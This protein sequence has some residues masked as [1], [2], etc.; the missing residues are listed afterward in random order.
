MAAYGNGG[1]AGD[2]D[3][4]GDVDIYVT[5][6]GRNELWS[7]LGD[8]TFA[9]VTDDAGVGESLWSSAA[10]FADVDRDGDLDLYVGNYVDFGLDNHK[11]CGEEERGI[12][13][14]CHP[15]AYS[16]LPDTFYRNEGDG[17]FVERSEE[18][19]LAGK[20]LATLALSFG[21][22]DGDGWPDLYVANDANRN[23]LFFNRG[24]GTFE[25][26]ALLAGVAFGDSGNPEAG[27][28]VDFGDVDL[29][30]DLDIFVTNF[31]LETNVLY[32]NL[33]Q[34]VF[35]DARFASNVAESSLLNLAF[36]AAFADLDSDGDL[37]VA[38]ANGHVLDNA[39]ELNKTSTYEQRNLVL[40]NRGDGT[41]EPVAD[42]GFE[43]E[44][45]SRG[46]ATADL[47]LDGDLDIVISNSD[48]RAEVYEN[49]SVE[50]PKWLAVDLRGETPNVFGIGA[51]LNL[52]RNE[53]GQLDEVRTGSS[54]A[55]QNSL[56]QHFGLGDADR[57]DA[58]EVSWPSGPG[59]PGL[60]RHQ[61]S[62]SDPIYCWQP[63]VMARPL[64]MC[65]SSPKIFSIWPIIR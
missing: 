52:L 25:E 27:M 47:D 17:T 44:R 60:K 48:D 2:Y 30:G 40:E 33:G 56:T 16:G 32:R 13:V 4:D 41:F 62:I 28:S 46:L 8:G 34:R 49:R 18:A 29:D 26:Q 24:D 3:G 5:A 63:V 38:V 14:Y 50:A 1:S 65:I 59:T 10:A 22:L 23:K 54:Y 42:A 39:A 9:E 53:R 45:V 6:F 58:L 36:G 15:G 19:G 37:D 11:F 57:V 20:S 21:D 43:D 64:S 61:S 35:I 12:R 7:N 31:E 51:R 55:S